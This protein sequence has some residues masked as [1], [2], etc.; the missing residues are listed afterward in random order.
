MECLGVFANSTA[1][2]LRAELEASLRR[3]GTDYIDL[4]QVHWPDT[5]TPIAETAAL[6]ADFQRE[7]KVRALGV[8]N[9]SVE[10]MEEFRIIAPLASDQPPYNLF[11][12]QIDERARRSCPGARPTQ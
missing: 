6:L 8:S 11:D 10:Q 7:G 1:S 3:L 4:Y 2:R 12:R 5:R 9:F